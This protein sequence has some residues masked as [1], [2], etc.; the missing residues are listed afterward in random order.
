LT[1]V[2]NNKE[3]E[4]FKENHENKLKKL[5]LDEKS[6]GNTLEFNKVKSLESTLASEK[7]KV[8]NTFSFGSMNYDNKLSLKKLPQAKTNNSNDWLNQWEEIEEVEKKSLLDWKSKYQIKS[9]KSISNIEDN[10]FPELA[11]TKHVNNKKYFKDNII[12]ERDS[13][14]ILTSHDTGTIISEYN[15][16]QQIENKKL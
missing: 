14:N 3:Y 16:G 8:L 5:D 6:L 2:I 4:I 15:I 11:S 13:E 10:D 7:L 12:W 9:N 1:N